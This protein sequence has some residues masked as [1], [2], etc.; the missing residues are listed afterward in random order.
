MQV[1]RTE[2]K[3]NINILLYPYLCAI[4]NTFGLRNISPKIHSSIGVYCVRRRSMSNDATRLVIVEGGKNGMRFIEKLKHLTHYQQELIRMAE[5]LVIQRCFDKDQPKIIAVEQPVT[6]NFSIICV[7]VKGLG[8]GKTLR[9]Q[10][11]IGRIQVIV[12]PL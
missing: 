4:S 12:D 9:I 6:L 2:K 1:N 5:I 10:T 8:C 3:G 11:H 7:A